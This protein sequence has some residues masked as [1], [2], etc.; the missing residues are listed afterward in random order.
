MSRIT[1]QELA[2]LT[3]PE[4]ERGLLYAL[5][6]RGEAVPDL[7]DPSVW[8]IHRY[9]LVYL[10]IRELAATGAALEPV[11][12]ADHLQA[13]GELEAAGVV[14]T[15]SELT[16]PDSWAGSAATCAKILRERARRRELAEA[17]ER[18][19]RAASTPG[20]DPEAV[21][22][23]AST[24]LAR[25][26]PDAQPT[27]ATWPDLQGEA[28]HGLAGDIVRGIDPHT[29]AD[30]AAVLVQLLAGFGAAVGRGPYLRAGAEF[31]RNTSVPKFPISPGSFPVISR[32]F[33]VVLRSMQRKNLDAALT[34]S[35]E[36]VAALRRVARSVDRT[37]RL[38]VVLGVVESNLRRLAR[39][40]PISAEAWA[41]AFEPSGSRASGV[42][43][44]ERGV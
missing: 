38:G 6:A 34:D 18:L 10:A 23:S 44:R 20:G 16:L 8:T 24:L 15:I 9:S 11:A 33:Q 28:L 19:V 21:L 17:G 5:L 40:L 13:R 41:E 35:I 29:E 36:N 39:G 30:Q 1:R 12:L 2:A 22:A 31:P 32:F 26:K 43:R 7:D 4:A 3:A 25:S 42:I 37:G 27:G 14:A